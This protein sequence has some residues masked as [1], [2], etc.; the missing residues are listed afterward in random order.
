M[1]LEEE[2]AWGTTYFHILKSLPR[3]SFEVVNST[4]GHNRHVSY[5]YR[6]HYREIFDLLVY[7]FLTSWSRVPPTALCPAIENLAI[8]KLE[9]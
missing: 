1:F 2:G 6:P 7:T 9:A 5:S 8:R 3:D 4:P